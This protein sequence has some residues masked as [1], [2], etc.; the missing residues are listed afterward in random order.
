M[1]KTKLIERRKSK[2]YSQQQLA[3][4]LCMNVSNYNR[5]EKGIAHIKPDEWTKLAKILET[6]ID[7]IYEPDTRYNINCKDQS[8]GIGVNNGTNNVYT[9]PKEFLDTQQK[10]ITLLEKKIIELSK[11]K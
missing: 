11:E 2:G 10:Y 9:V 5:R 7:E 3:N 6:S 1:L 8:V 4:L